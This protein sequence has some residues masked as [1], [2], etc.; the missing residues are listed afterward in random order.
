[1][2]LHFGIVHLALNMWALWD[3]GR[4]MER[5]YRPLALRPA[6]SGQWPRRQPA[7]AGGAGQQGGIGRRLGRR[8]QPVRRACWCSC[9][10]NAGMCSGASSAG[11][12][13]LRLLFTLATLVMGLVVPGIDN[14]AHVGG[15]VCGALLAQVLARPWAGNT[16]VPPAVSRLAALGLLG[17]AVATLVTHIPPP[18]YRMGDELRAQAA[19]R[20]FLL[21]DRVLSQRWDSLIDSGR[22]ERLSFDQLAG[23]IDK[24]V[25][26]EYQE[27]FEELAG[28]ELGAGARQPRHWK[29][30]ATT[31]TC[32]V[33]PPMRWQRACAP[34]T[35]KKSARRWRPLA[36]RP[37]W[38]SGPWRLRLPHRLPRRPLLPPALTHRAPVVVS[39][40]CRACA[41]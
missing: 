3:V 32:A 29:C 24:R 17:I 4:L 14:A 8:I 26:S 27:N 6:L 7:V 31:P 2:F 13:A 39:P 25:A 30:C 11:C 35:P 18:T 20:K 9:G 36:R 38:R 33:M 37:C 5:L 28:L 21:E 12:S 40:A 10:A 15:L 1:L 16:R 41:A 34:R 23:A 19:I 22:R